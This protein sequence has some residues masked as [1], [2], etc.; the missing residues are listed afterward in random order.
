MK[1]YELILLLA[2]CAALSFWTGYRCGQDTAQL[3]Y[4]MKLDEIEG[5]QK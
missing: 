1:R 4:E 2:F 3:N 5:Q